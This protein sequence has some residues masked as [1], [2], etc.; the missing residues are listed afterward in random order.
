MQSTIY[1]KAKDPLKEAAIDAL[2]RVVDP[3]IGLMF[4]TGI[5][6]QEFA[7]LVRDRA[8]RSAASR[9]AKESGRV[10]NSRV[11]IITGLARAEVARIL[12]TD[13]SAL[14]SGIG[15][16]PA[17]K[18]LSAWHDNQRFLDA[19]G[20][21][22]VL[23]IF[24]T[25]KSFEQLV[26]SFGGGSPVRAMLD[27]LIEIGA[28][29]VL[30]GQRVRVR[31][32]VPMFRG[33]TNSAIANFGERTGDLLETLR[34]NLHAT[35]APLFEGTAFVTDVDTAIAPLVRRQ[36]AEQGAAFIDSANSLLNRS[37]GKSNRRRS[38]EA[39]LPRMGVT[40][41]YFEEG[42]TNDSSG[43]VSSSRRRKNFQRRAGKSRLVRK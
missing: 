27:Q 12:A 11:A 21:P 34:G 20:N 41:F 22:A 4:D 40:V 8:V 14:E 13:G 43:G 2:K 7:R 16:H 1:Q 36:I 6:V 32:R 24:G 31:A 15:Q 3:L 10:N 25:R 37:R 17:R 9:I 5:T 23:P 19:S 29:D 39:Q 28:V 38:T 33:M 26:L 42:F 35:A 30:S 18:L